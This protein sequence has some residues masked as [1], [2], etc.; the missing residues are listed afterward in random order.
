MADRVRDFKLPAFFLKKIDRQRREIDQPRD[1]LGIVEQLVQ[2]EDR[3]D[4]ATER[5]QRRQ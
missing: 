4:F 1:E 3:C 2:I 5:K